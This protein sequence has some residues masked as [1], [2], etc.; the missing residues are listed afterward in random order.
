MVIGLVVPELEE[1]GS[2]LVVPVPPVAEELE[3]EEALEEAEPEFAEPEELVVAAAVV[4]VLWARAG[5]WPET[6]W[7]KITPQTNANMD[8]AVASA[9]LRIKATRRRRALSL[10]AAPARGPELVV[11]RSL[12]VIVQKAHTAASEGRVTEVRNS[13]EG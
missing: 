10:D 2:V 12:E 4:L 5:S 9:R 1:L 13:Y 11:G 6:S 3:P 7:T 8:A